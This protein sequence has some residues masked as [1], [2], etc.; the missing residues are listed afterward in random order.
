MSLRTTPSDCHGLRNPCGLRVGLARVRVRVGNFQPLAYP[1][2]CHGLGVTREKSVA[3]GSNLTKN[4]YEFAAPGF[5]YLVPWRISKR[6]TQAI[7]SGFTR[8]TTN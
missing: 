6:A 7:F 5:A 2:P 8:V 1:D 3:K 4:S